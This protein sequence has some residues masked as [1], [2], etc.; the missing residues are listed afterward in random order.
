MDY[1]LDIPDALKNKVNRA[2]QT[3]IE[4]CQTELEAVKKQDVGLYNGNYSKNMMNGQ[5]QIKMTN[6]DVYKGQFK[7]N[8]RHGSGICMFKSGGLYRGEFRN[9]MPDGQGI[10]FSGSNEIIE[11]RFEKG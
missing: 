10:L 3:F 4:D 8:L 11:C 6:G 1:K 2:W 5:G 7:N 9:D